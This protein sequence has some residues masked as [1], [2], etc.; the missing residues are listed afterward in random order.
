MRS[1]SPRPEP[2]LVHLQVHV[3]P[4]A[5]LPPRRPEHD[6]G[7]DKDDTGDD[8]ENTG[9]D[10]RGRRA[11]RRSADDAD[12]ADDDVTGESAP[13]TAAPPWSRPAI[14]SLVLANVFLVSP[15]LLDDVG[16]LPW[17]TSAPDKI[18]M[19]ALPAS[20]LWLGLV[21]MQM[22]SLVL[23]HALLLPFYVAVGVDLF[24]LFH[25]GTRLS[26]SMI[27]VFLQNSS[28]A[29]AYLNENRAQVVSAVVVVVVLW[30][31]ALFGLRGATWRPALPVRAFFAGSLVV[32]YG[33]LVV[34]QATTHGST[35]SGVVDVV[36]HDRNS[37]FG[38]IP[39]G[40]V[41]ASVNA[42]VEQHRAAVSSVRFGAT[43]AARAVP[44]VVVLVIGESAR[45]DRWG[46]Y[47][48]SRATTPR[49][50]S[51][52]GLVVF[53]DV[54]TQAALTQLAVPLMLTRGPLEKFDALL[55]R[56]SVISA[57][58]EAGYQTAWFSTQQRDQWTGAVNLFSAE[59]DEQRFFDRRHDDVLVDALKGRLQRLDNDDSAFIVLHTQGSHYT[60]KDRYPADAAP[61]AT[62]GSGLSE[63]D[64]LLN[65]YDNTV[66]FTDQVLGDVIGALEARGGDA[67][68][69][70]VADHG[71]NLRDD[72]RMLFGH[73]IGN[74][75]DLRVPMVLW[76]S[77]SYAER[78]PRRMKAAVDN[79][80]R[81]ISTVS[82]FATLLQ[83]ADVVIDDVPD[84]E[85]VLSAR[86]SPRPREVLRG[87]VPVDADSVIPNARRSEGLA[88]GTPPDRDRRRALHGD[89]SDD[90]SP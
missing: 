52:P 30:A 33:A 79:A 22:R 34:R 68:M 53:R 42:S 76:T 15:V 74:E 13:A 10:D 75:Y 73:F 7:D 54:L 77:S 23:A 9:D 51:V 36:S 24:L 6:A 37:P 62:V 72:D 16:L 35:L 49:L 60:F 4:A 67:V 44:T 70:Y 56:K 25:Y 19:F 29:G 2:T 65:E 3:V 88:G 64:R 90:D 83:A 17:S 45:P 46:L 59:A 14:A 66:A 50:E 12:A 63:H 71:E 57:V 55:Q 11:D 28:D 5:A 40:L 20:L 89:A 47:N 41:A 1:R 39:Q 27:A 26:S 78:H 81:P 85:G 80:R 86:F 32:L 61:F 38:V 69:L 84:D 8:D 48:A 18:A 31:A 58:A 43:R 82:I 21:Q 87:W